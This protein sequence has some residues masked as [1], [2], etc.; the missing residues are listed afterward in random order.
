M[1]LGRLAA[2]IVEVQ[3]SGERI[4]MARFQLDSNMPESCTLITFY[5]I[6]LTLPSYHGKFFMFFQL[7]T[8][9]AVYQDSSH[10]H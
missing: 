10:E 9:R 7:T 3:P 2:E 4:S 1:G 6:A 5:I 8:G